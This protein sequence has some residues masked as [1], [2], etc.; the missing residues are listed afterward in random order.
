MLEVRNLSKKYFLKPIL[1]GI[2]FSLEPNQITALVGVN[3][4]GKTTLLKTMVNLLPYHSGEIFFKKKS[5]EKDIASYLKK[6]RFL[7]ET[8]PLSDELTPMEYF[9]FVSR[10]WLIKEDKDKLNYFLKKLRIFERRNSLIK[11]LSKGLR[12]RVGLIASLLGEPELLILDEPFSG[13]DP[14]QILELRDF[15][16]ELKKTT[17]IFFSTHLLN[18]INQI[19]DKVIFIHQGKIIGEEII[20]PNDTFDNMLNDFPLENGYLIELIKNTLVNQ[21]KLLN[22][23]KKEKI[24]YE[25]KN[26]F[27]WISNNSNLNINHLLATL[28]QTN[29]NVKKITFVK[30]NLENTFLHY[31]KKI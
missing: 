19:A 22:Y 4:A 27:L 20:P 30:K 15:L 10:L 18:E 31:L 26:R 25:K 7:G 2:S 1:Q 3:G 8:N 14:R 29:N 21:K 13:L 16:L 24:L 28:N 12:Q 5:L 11:N 6:V 9:R 23:F 17:S